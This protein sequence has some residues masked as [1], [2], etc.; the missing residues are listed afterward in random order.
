M[1]G[2]CVRRPRTATIRRVSVV[3]RRHAQR[4]CHAA[5]PD[6]GRAQQC[7][8]GGGD[9]SAFALQGVNALPA[10]VNNLLIPGLQFNTMS[11]RF[12][13]R[14]GNAPLAHGLGMAFPGLEGTVSSIGRVERVMR[15]TQRLPSTDLL[16]RPGRRG[17]GS[18][19]AENKRKLRQRR[20]SVREERTT[21]REEAAAGRATQVRYDLRSASLI[22]N[23]EQEEA[24]LARERAQGARYY[25]RGGSSGTGDSSSLRTPL[26]KTHRK[27]EQ[28]EAAL[29]R[30]RARGARSYTRGGSSGTGDSSSLRS[31]LGK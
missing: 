29:A 14:G 31:P 26:S 28:E 9:G 1:R 6:S 21:T 2:A 4:Q 12:G 13:F 30:E 10:A 8:R 27:Q 23:R 7:V 22:G 5:T 11:Q 24:A 17:Q 3:T 15:S 20:G 16:H 18:S 25:T 19:E